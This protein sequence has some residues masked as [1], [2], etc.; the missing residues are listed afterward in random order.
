MRAYVKANRKVKDVGPI[1]RRIWSVCETRRV[2]EPQKRRRYRAPRG[3]RFDGNF[4]ARL[5]R[6]SPPSLTRPT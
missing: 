3:L 2:C 5:E 1:T 4:P 6:S